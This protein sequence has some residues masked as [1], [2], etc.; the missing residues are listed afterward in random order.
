MNNLMRSMDDKVFLGVC[1][2]IGNYF[3]V[4]P[5]IIRL[6]FIFFG[7]MNFG[8]ALIGYIIAAFVMPERDSARY[9]DRD[10]DEDGYEDMREYDERNTTMKKNGPVFIGLGLILLG[11]YLLTELIVP[12]LFFQLRQL[13]NFWPVLLILLGFYVIYQNKN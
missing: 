2:G 5:T 8:M 9:E 13:W 1:S 3:N 10:P 12:N 6:I 4:D 11:A 7:F